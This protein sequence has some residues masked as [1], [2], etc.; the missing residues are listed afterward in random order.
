M[1]EWTPEQKEAIEARGENILVAAAAGSGKTAVLT[2][3]ILR[4]VTEDRVPVSSLLVL[5]F[6]DA[7]AAEMRR[8]IEG[9]LAAALAEAE[10]GPQ[11][12]GASDGAAF[13]REQ[14]RRL[15]SAQISTFHS[16]ALNVLR[17]YYYTIGVEPSLK[18]CDE[19]RAAIMKQDALDRLFEERFASGSAAFTDFLGRYADGRSEDAVRGMAV[20]CYDFIR[21]LPDPFEWLDAAVARL[22]ASDEEYIAGGEFAAL[23]ENIGSELALARDELTQV[24]DLL[25]GAGLAKLAAKNAADMAELSGAIDVFG[26]GSGWDGMGAAL[27]FGF[28]RFVATKDEKEGYA[29]IKDELTAARDSA[30]K[31]LRLLRDTYFAR[32]LAEMIADVRATQPQALELAGLVRGFHEIFSELKRGEG[33]IDFNDIEHFALEILRDENVCAELREKYAHIFVDE[34]QDSNYVQEALVGRICRAGN[35]FMVGDVKQSIYR[36]RH[37]EPAIFADK[38]NRYPSEDGCCR[39]DLN[40]N[41][42][43]KAPVIAAVNG[44]FS[45]LM[46]DGG[47]AGIAYDENA[48]L[49]QGLG[50]EPKWDK[51]VELRVVDVAASDE[52]SGEGVGEIMSMKDMEREAL[53]AAAVIKE[54]RGRVFYDAKRGVERPMEYGDMVV[55]LREARNSGSVFTEILLGEGIDAYA[56]SGDGYLGTVEIET[57]MNLLRVI[58]NE[59]QDVP[60]VSALYSPVFGFTTDELAEIRLASTGRTTPYHRAFLSCIEMEDSVLAQKCRAALDLILKWRRDESFMELS[61]FLWLVLKESGWFDYAGALAGGG[62]RQANL[63][64]MTVRAA[65]Y[66]SGRARG[67]FG[68]IKYIE[69]VEDKKLPIPQAKL[70]TEG[71]DVVRVMTIHK[72]KGLEYPLVIVAG[73]GKRFPAVGRGERLSL[74]RECGLALTL[75]N[76]EEHTWRKTLGALAIASRTAEEERAEY[77]R[78]LYVAMTRAQD[79]LVLIG[80]K[81]NIPEMEHPNKHNRDGSFCVINEHEQQHKENRSRCATP[82]GIRR[83]TTFLDMLLPLAPCAGMR[84][85]VIAPPGLLQVAQESEAEKAHA[86]EKIAELA[87]LPADTDG[88]GTYYGEVDARLSFSYPHEKATRLKSKYSVSELNKKAAKESVSEKP[89]RYYMEESEAAAREDEGSAG[90]EPDAFTISCD[91]PYIP[92]IADNEPDTA[93]IA[94]SAPQAP[95][96]NASGSRTDAAMRGTAL[97]KALEKLDFAAARAN[98]DNAAW[99]E[100]YLDRLAGAGFLTAE[101][102]ALTGALDLM[103][104]AASDICARAAA[105]SDAQAQPPAQAAA[106]APQPQQPPKAHSTSGNGTPTAPRHIGVRRETPFNYRMEMDGESIIVQ[107]IID[108]FFE[109]GGELV[110]V[111]F[112]SGGGAGSAEARAKRAREAYGEQLRLYREALEAITGKKVKE[113]LMYLTSTGESVRL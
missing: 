9:A 65:E 96:A 111:D 48:A 7:A 76:P 62:L 41:F 33:V 10:S 34:Y 100:S 91:E 47:G 77:L 85:S 16:F 2:E 19:F 68:F 45:C 63:R 42:R 102:R 83:A 50:Y 87:E 89:A 60:L 18:V 64:A 54:A 112:K 38:Y 95:R 72:S 23:C 5:T 101:Q 98:A 67:L 57:F 55:L 92:V 84:L 108:L 88:G 11:G 26:G 36:F 12:A 17:T 103:S 49:K 20:R 61:D 78:V 93:A 56:E 110:L 1:P 6:T 66:G 109:E 40:R 3:R 30:K 24:G 32:P 35:R 15:R 46:G 52:E 105:A 80:S 51:P 90:S 79:R 44:V 13:L 27:S 28:Q 107:G 97:H 4:L 14:S 25:D 104:F 82:S 39:I 113:T 86:T 69:S 73:L 8:R 71:D 106:E 99:F 94:G 22:G 53:A 43:S 31:R 58:D 75:E 70:V 29:E 37:A 21:S 74:H 59:R 81:K